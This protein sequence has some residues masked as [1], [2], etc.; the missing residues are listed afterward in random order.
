MQAVGQIAQKIEDVKTRLED[1]KPVVGFVDA[2]WPCDCYDCQILMLTE[3]KT[4]T[5]EYLFLRCT[6]PLWQ[7]TPFGG[8]CTPKHFLH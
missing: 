4:R 2:T 5:S 7:T 3:F 6:L 8:L 1:Y